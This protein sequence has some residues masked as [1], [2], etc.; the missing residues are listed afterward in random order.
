MSKELDNI[1]LGFLGTTETEFKTVI[2]RQTLISGVPVG[3]GGC[4]AIRLRL[5]QYERNSVNATNAT[6]TQ[7]YYGDSNAQEVELLRGTWSELI[8][9]SDL[10]KVFVRNP[11]STAANVQIMV[12]K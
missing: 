4:R 1:L 12:Y 11:F 9:C 3:I 10:N 2:V 8:V 7:V 5:N 6:Q